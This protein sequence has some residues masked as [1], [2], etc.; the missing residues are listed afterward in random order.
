[1]M[2]MPFIF[3][4]IKDNGKGEKEGKI[5]WKREKYTENGRVK[6]RLREISIFVKLLRGKYLFWNN[7]TLKIFIFKMLPEHRTNRSV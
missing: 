7:K 3:G 2:G 6:N 4:W 1:M 5:K